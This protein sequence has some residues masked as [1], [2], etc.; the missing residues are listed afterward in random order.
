MRKG[1]AIAGLTLAILAGGMVS[2]PSPAL[3]AGFHGGG[4]G[5]FH[6]GGGGFHGGGFHGGFGGRGFHGG[7]RGGFRGS[8][9]FGGF[10]GGFYDPWWGYPY[11]Y[12]Y[13]SGYYPYPYYYGYDPAAYVAPV[14]AAPGPATA[15]TQ[16]AAPGYDQSYCR[17]YKT[18][19][20]VGGKSTS[21]TGTACRQ[22]DGSWRIVQ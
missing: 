18:N 14:T 6:G 16:A 4:G 3:A 12:P 7:F 1:L 15:P 20:Q 21:A 2:T 8:F 13:Y 17:P 19:I 10:G 11:A 22:A 9:F 5:G